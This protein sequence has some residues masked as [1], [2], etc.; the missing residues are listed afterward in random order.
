M[1]AEDK[2]EKVRLESIS[3]KARRLI[4]E[5]FGFRGVKSPPVFVPPEPKGPPAVDKPSPPADLYAVRAHTRMRMSLGR[6]G[7]GYPRHVEQAAAATAVSNPGLGAGCAAHALGVIDGGYGK[8]KRGHHPRYTQSGTRSQYWVYRGAHLADG[9]RIPPL[10]LE[11]AS[12]PG[13]EAQPGDVITVGPKGAKPAHTTVV[14]A[15]TSDGVWCIGYNQSGVK[16]SGLRTSGELA[17]TYY[18]LAP[19]RDY[20]VHK[21]TTVPL[22]AYEAGPTHSISDADVAR[23]VEAFERLAGVSVVWPSNT[24]A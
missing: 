11:Y 6:W 14:I 10:G 20:S 16:A 7:L 18:T 15:R 24:T 13:R 23:G 5:G 12:R 3:E 2:V 19:G 17:L 1:S 22:D 8:R 21:V 4:R 9:T